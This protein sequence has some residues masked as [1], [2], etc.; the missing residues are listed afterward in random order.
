MKD[1]HRWKVQLPVVEAVEWESTVEVEQAVV[2]LLT[3]MRIWLEKL[4]T[5]A[6]GQV[7]VVEL[8]LLCCL[9]VLVCSPALEH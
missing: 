2:S 4:M 1:E 3:V 5:R 6:W 7:A 9:I 8:L